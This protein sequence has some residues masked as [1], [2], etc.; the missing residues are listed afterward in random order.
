MNPVLL[1]SRSAKKEPAPKYR[2]PDLY[3]AIRL[4]TGFLLD[5]RSV[6]HG[7]VPILGSA[8][9]RDPQKWIRE[10]E[11]RSDKIRPDPPRS[12]TRAAIQ[13]REPDLL[14]IWYWLASCNHEPALR[15]IDMI[16]NLP[17]FLP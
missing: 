14:R 7:S 4:W 2:D 16:G 9:N 13:R 1:G 17:V 12:A 10:P 3:G 15:F 11:P 8:Q 6:L 5:L